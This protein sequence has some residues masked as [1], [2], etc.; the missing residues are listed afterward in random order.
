VTDAKREFWER[1][2]ATVERLKADPEA[3]QG[4]L[5][6]IAEWDA[7]AGDGLENEEPY[8][9]PEEEA[10]IEAEYPRTFRDA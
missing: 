7:L 9:T 1:A 3:W 6:E 8:Y 2:A 4:Y 10:E 5:D